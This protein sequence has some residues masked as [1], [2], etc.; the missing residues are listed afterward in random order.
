MVA[1][2][3]EATKKL[4]QGFGDLFN[5]ITIHRETTT[6]FK[7]VKL[8][9]HFAPASYDYADI[10][11]HPSL[12][13]V[14]PSL[15]LPLMT[16]EIT[17]YEVD[18]SRK[19][20][21][22]YIRNSCQANENGTFDVIRSPTPYN[23]GLNLYLFTHYLD[24]VFE[25][26]EKI[27]SGFNPKVTIRVKQGNGIVSEVPISFTGISKT[28]G[29]EGSPKDKSRLITTTFSFEAKMDFYRT[30]GETVELIKKITLNYKDPISSKTEFTTEISVDPIDADISDNWT[31]SKTIY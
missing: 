28:D 26:Q 16:Y 18:T 20:N 24:D 11:Q 25:V 8:P 22:Y 2:Y 23:V 21:R 17:R 3:N 7:P 15:K 31:I 13:E 4:L 6:G 9:I 10:L 30:T 12:T 1:T 5:N 27:Y 19:E 29:Y 14:R